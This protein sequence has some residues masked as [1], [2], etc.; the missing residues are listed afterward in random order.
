MN[1]TEMARQAYHPAR[2]FLRDGRSTEAQ[3]FG[4]ITS[5][6]QAAADSGFEGFARLAEALH[7]NREL[8]SALAIDVADDENTLP[9]PLRAQIFYLAEF[10]FLHTSKVLRK[11]ADA[12]VLI[13]I[14]RAVMR[15]LNRAEA[16]Q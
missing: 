4:Q 7:E 11:E 14:N 10:T 3:L 1:A 2:S 5:R 13:E 16:A 15:G 6:L 9:A 12:D 8:W